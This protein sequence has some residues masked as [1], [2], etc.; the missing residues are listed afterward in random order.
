MGR[1]LMGSWL[2][3]EPGDADEG[4]DR[5]DAGEDGDSENDEF[6]DGTEGFGRCC[7]CEKAEVRLGL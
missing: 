3:L 2:G 6:G 4:S 1:S 7:C 5:P